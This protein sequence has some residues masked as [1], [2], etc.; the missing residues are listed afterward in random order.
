MPST[1]PANPATSAVRGLVSQQRLE[2]QLLSN[3]Y[4][5]R[6]SSLLPTSEP[7]IL[8]NEDFRFEGWP[9]T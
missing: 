4:S 3:H 8:T 7:E 1:Q 9:E 5:I 2:K 6:F